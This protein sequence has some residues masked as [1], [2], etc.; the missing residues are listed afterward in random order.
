MQTL[1]NGL[2][3]FFIFVVN[4]LLSPLNTII[5]TYVP[6]LTNL[7]MSLDSYFALIN[8]SF[9]PWIKDLFLLEQW[10]YTLVVAFITF[11]LIAMVGTNAYKLILRYWETLV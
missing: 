11:R 8:D 4:I 6:D 3:S 5:N 7:I 9:I 10:V 2:L 1:V